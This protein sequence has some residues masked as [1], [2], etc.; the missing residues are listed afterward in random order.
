MPFSFFLTL[1][2]SIGLSLFSVETF[3]KK[4]QMVIVIDDIGYRKTDAAVLTLPGNITF[5]VLP[6]TPYG[7]TLALE[8]NQQNKDV[9]LHIPMESTIGKKLGPGAITSDMN[10][11][12]VQQ[13]L[14]K[15]L[16]EIPFAIGI[17]NHMGSKLTQLYSPMA[18]TMRYLKEKD[19]LFLDSM[20][21]KLSKGEQVAK[22]FGVPS[23]HRH[24]FLDNQLDEQYI[25]KQFNQLIQIA[26][27]HPHAV[28]IAHPHPETIA[29]LTKLI[30]TLKELNIELVS[31]SNVIA[32]QKA[33]YTTAQITE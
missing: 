1:I 14:D 27:Q 13:Q 12:E 3:A 26:Q 17:N 10:E 21:T 33:A 8:A 11:N 4:N 32:K 15:A 20:T 6:H 9:L 16:V 29:A 28:G 2:L 5:S 19:L 30:P 23:L 18:W 31:I 7:K 22:L 24:V 25:T